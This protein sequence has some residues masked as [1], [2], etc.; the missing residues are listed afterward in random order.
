MNHVLGTW[1]LSMRTPIGTMHAV[2]TFADDGH[3]LTGTA[4]GRAE[5]VPLRDVQA[6]PDGRQGRV[7]WNQTIT[8]P[9]RLELSFDVGIE[10]NQMTGYSRAGK[11]PR[12][13][14]TGTRRDT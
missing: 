2:L 8:T 12:T 1:D 11:L 6:V 7:T 10:G 14:V 13:T 5:R 9:M 4:E 3:G